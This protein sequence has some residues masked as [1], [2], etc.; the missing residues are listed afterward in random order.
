ME[1][2]SNELRVGMVLLAAVIVLVGGIMWAKGFS[3]KV[4]QYDITVVFGDVQGL[5]PGSN[6]LANGVE[7]GRVHNIF[8]KEGRVYVSASIDKDVKLFQD[9]RITVDSP[10]LLAGKVLSVYPGQEMPYTNTDTVL[11]GSTTLGMAQ[12]VEMFKDISSDLKLAFNN[13]NAVLVSLDE[14]IGDSVSQANIRGTIANSA[15]MA[16]LS[17]EWLRDNR[18]TLTETL[19]RVEETFVKAQELMASTQT[20]LSTSMNSF[21]STLVQI[22]GVAA[23]LR[24]VLDGLNSDQTTAGKL[25][26]DDELYVRLNTVLAELEGLAGDVRTRGLKMRHT[27]KIF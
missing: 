14:V 26:H 9:Y 21:D 1:R 4:R 17:A 15:D 19:N 7:K 25:L 23:S 27:L 8:L 3:L 5:E 10:S 11:I 18:Q 16:K 12:A 13:L 22:N 2:S 6:V 20:Q 24:Q